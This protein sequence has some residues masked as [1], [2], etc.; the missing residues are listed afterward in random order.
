[1]PSPMQQNLE[2]VVELELEGDAPGTASV[3][4]LVDTSLVAEALRELATR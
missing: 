3:E 4:R 2:A 1:M